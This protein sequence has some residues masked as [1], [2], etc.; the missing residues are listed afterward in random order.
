MVRSKRKVNTKSTTK[1]SPTI[2]IHFGTVV[3][4]FFTKE[5]PCLESVIAVMI[6]TKGLKIAAML[7]TNTQGLNKTIIVLLYIIAGS[8]PK[9]DLYLPVTAACRNL[10]VNPL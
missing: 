4:W 3:G 8:V 5:K 9:M 2:H 7:S 10:L 6:V 1:T